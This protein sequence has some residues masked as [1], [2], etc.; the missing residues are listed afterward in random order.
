MFVINVYCVVKGA[1]VITNFKINGESVV[2]GHL[3]ANVLKIH[4]KYIK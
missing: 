1:D 3:W 4:F 2:I